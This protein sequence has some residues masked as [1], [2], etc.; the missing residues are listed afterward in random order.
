MIFAFLPLA[1]FKTIR[2]PVPE[3]AEASNLAVE[4]GLAVA[5]LGLL[6]AAFL[7]Q[8]LWRKVPPRP[9]P[10][11]ETWLLIDGSN[12]MHW[13][14]NTPSLEPVQTVI[15]HLKGLGYVPGVV[16]DANAGWKLFGHYV[17]DRDFAKVLR[18]E[19]E[20]VL[21]VP[22]GTQA[23]PYLLQTARDFGVRIISNDRFRDWSADYPEVAAPGFLIPGSLVGGKLQLAGLDVAVQPRA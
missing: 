9:R 10:V 4:A 2:L 23:D 19:R 8:R 22:K 1:D 15:D 14:D 11:P 21:V 7:L 3:A 6:G 12:V 20:Q 17:D 18:I 16:F 13:V 5:L